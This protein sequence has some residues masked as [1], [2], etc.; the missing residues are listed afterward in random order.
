MKIYEY[1]GKH[2]CDEDLS[3]TDDAYAGD[4]YDLYWELRQ[5][6]E[7]REETRYYSA[8]N[9]EYSF[10]SAEDLVEDYCEDMLV[11]EP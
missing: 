5:K 6:G 11:A 10:E 4:L 2:Y 7:L 3:M 9:P 8:V 1:E